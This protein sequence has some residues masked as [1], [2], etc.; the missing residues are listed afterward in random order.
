M[1][2]LGEHTGI[3]D[4]WGRV[5]D[6]PVHGGARTR[7]TLLSVM[8]YLF[9]VQCILGVLLSMYYSP[10]A[11]AAWASTAY[12][13]DQVS[14]GW[15]VRG[16]HHHLNSVLLVVALL[17]VVA[18]AVAGGYRKPREFLWF[19]SLVTVVI[20]MFAG[21]TGN[22]LPWDEQGY[23]AAQVELGILEQSPGGG[24]IRTLAEGGGDPGNLTLTRMFTL[25][26]FALPLLLGAM[27]ALAFAVRR[28][29][30][31][32]AGLGTS[33]DQAASAAEPYFP[34]QMFRDF[35]AMAAVT[36]V[37]V[38]LT[39][40]TEGS[41]LYAP[42]DPT[43]GFQ[44]R[45]E[46][47][48]LA[49]YQLRM[50]FEG[51]LEPVATLVLPG[52]VGAAFIASPWIDR[53]TGKGGRF[54]VLGVVGAVGI[55]AIGL[56]ALA[57]A[58]DA[59]NEEYQEALAIAHKQADK[60][61]G[62]AR[63]GVLPEGGLAVYRNDP[64]YKVAMLFK[65]ECQN[66]HEI[67]GIGGDEAPDLTDYGSIA[68][69]TD[70]IRNPNDERF[71]GGTKHDGMDPYPEEDL[72]A[73]QLE[74]VAA[75]LAS[76]TG[77]PTVEAD[78]ALVAKGETL[79][80]KELDCD[81]CHE[82]TPGESGDGPNLH[83]HA[84]KAWVAR[85]IANSSAEDLYGENAQMPEFDDKLSKEEIEALAEWITRQRRGED[86]EAAGAEEASG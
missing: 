38:V 40:V 61:R 16:L 83:D 65:E 81:G 47:Y 62:F 82:L 32:A 69:R 20:L 76:K 80:N 12:V 3:A 49:L 29:F 26:A 8:L 24:A 1:G 71:F 23:W 27:L 78:P 36:V 53:G 59:G 25:H 21:V 37:G 13:Q 79:W 70:L 30:G 5:A 15:F 43:S 41:E 73:D 64:D 67:D 42:A 72:P 68:W 48:F 34:R 33:D 77:E 7:H 54:A 22:I 10:S 52:L 31:D 51:P 2:W 19:S 39:F 74:A 58:K 50:F 18:L 6:R 66:C 55:G 84:S 35:A 46:W 4:A 44:A 86:A 9:V 63:E 60:A 75:F 28:K 56:T 57:M 85:V 17:H 45:P 11:S 14:S